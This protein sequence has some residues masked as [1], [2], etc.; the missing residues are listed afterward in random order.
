MSK[1][2]EIVWNRQPYESQIVALVIRDAERRGYVDVCWDDG[3]PFLIGVRTLRDGLETPAL[4]AWRGVAT[5]NRREVRDERSAPDVFAEAD[6]NNAHAAMAARL[7]T[8]RRDR[9]ARRASLPLP[10]GSLFDE[11][12]RA[13]TELFK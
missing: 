4:D 2:R 10:A 13:Q 11:V 12:T 7:E 8:V 3:R 1:P 9:E 5:I 6:A